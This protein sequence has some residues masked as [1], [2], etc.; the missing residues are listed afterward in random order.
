MYDE[1]INQIVVRK[2]L[3]AYAELVKSQHNNNRLLESMP[4]SP[5]KTDLLAKC[6]TLRNVYTSKVE[7]LF[8]RLAASTNI[9]RSNEVPTV[10]GVSATQLSNSLLYYAALA[11]AKEKEL[12]YYM[13]LVQPLPKT[14]NGMSGIFDAFLPMTSA[15]VIMH[16][17]AEDE[18]RGLKTLRYFYDKAI[19]YPEVT[20]S[21]DE[22]IAEL[23]KKMSLAVNSIGMTSFTV[24]EG[25]I[26]FD[27]A[28]LQSVM[29]QL[30][31]TGQGQ[32]PEN[33]M[34]FSSAI[35]QSASNPSFWT[36]VKYTTAA[37]V[38]DI[39]RAVVDTSQNLITGVGGV[40]K[41]LKYL[42]YILLGGG[43][44]YIFTMAGGPMKLLKG[45]KKG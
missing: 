3:D 7:G 30:A 18:E 19:I 6:R 33:W 28:K 1:T 40:S 31:D 39:T 24:L 2:A 26:G 4:S 9:T 37:S 25:G 36:S 27:E 42:P 12:Y 38:G 21:F 22:F 8:N 23:K 5:Q 17:D 20:M 45:M 16:T 44:L 43:A 10:V 15:P 41:L 14:N 13:S 35:T 34:S 32:I 29:E 11:D